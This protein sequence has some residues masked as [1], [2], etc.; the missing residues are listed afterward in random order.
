[1][2]NS[3]SAPNTRRRRQGIKAGL[4]LPQILSAASAI[5]P[6]ELTMQAVADRL[7]VDRKAVNH[8]VSDR[9]TLLRLVAV[10]AYTRSFAAVSIPA[11][12]DWREASRIYGHGIASAVIALG[13]LARHVRVGAS[14]DALLLTVT[15]AVLARYVQAGFDL[16]TGLRALSMLSDICEAYAHGVVG[17]AQDGAGKRDLWL[18][19]VLRDLPE[20]HPRYLGE[21]V[22]SQ[23]YTYDARQL[24]ISIEIYI[25]GVEA[26]TAEASPP[27]NE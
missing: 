12:C 2:V 18:R 24:E 10:D 4:D 23:I 6:D 5:A 1:M 26:L 16:E 14:A 11:D 25:R 27:L 15:E 3:A 20:Q 7:G 13:P 17:M 22:E 8:H 19:E 9:E 21:A